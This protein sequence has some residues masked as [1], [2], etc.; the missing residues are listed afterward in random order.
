MTPQDFFG[1][2]LP[3]TDGDIIKVAEDNDLEPAVIKAVFDTEAAGSPFL[4]DGR[5]KILFEAHKF[6]SATGHRYN[7]VRDTRGHAISSNAWDRSLYG[8]AGAWQYTRLAL[9]MSLNEEAALKSTSWG[10]FQILGSNYEDCDYDTVFQMVQDAVQSAAG[11]LR[12][13][14]SFCDSNNLLG[15]LR[16]KQWALF[17][18]HYNGPAYKANAYDRKLDANFHKEAAIFAARVSNTN[19]GIEIQHGGAI[20]VTRAQLASVQA[21]LNA[22]HI[23]NPPLVVD[24]WT[25]PKTAAAISAFQKASGLKDTGQVDADLLGK[26]GI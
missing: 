3:L 10:A 19:H 8:G 7:S 14:I 5:P 22:L 16:S 9:A 17:A 24:G 23:P 2:H 18:E 4:D 1:S 6:G 12:A 15:Y 11:Q 25:G 21:A 13:F 20:V 26:L